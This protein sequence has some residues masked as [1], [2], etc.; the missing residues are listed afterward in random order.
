MPK[1]FVAN[2]SGYDYEKAEKHG[3]LIFMTQGYVNYKKLDSLI[4]KLCAQIDTSSPE[5]FLL[6]SGNNFLCA[7]ALQRW[8]AR[9][10]LCNILHYNPDKADYDRYNLNLEV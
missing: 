7:L 3:E 6:L 5:D 2:H 8:A 9:H 4:K 1:V 10:G